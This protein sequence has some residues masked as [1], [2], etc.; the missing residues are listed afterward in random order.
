MWIDENVTPTGLVIKGG[1]TTVDDEHPFEFR[2]PNDADGEDEITRAIWNN[3][4]N[5]A[6]SL[7]RWDEIC[8]GSDDQPNSSTEYI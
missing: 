8:S 1:V 5:A 4:K 7:N 3:I 2:L 6:D